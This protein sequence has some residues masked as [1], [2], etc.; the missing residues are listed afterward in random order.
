MDRT[1]S[2]GM[3]TMPAT[4]AQPGLPRERVRASLDEREV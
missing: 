4:W 2:G 3:T 1:G